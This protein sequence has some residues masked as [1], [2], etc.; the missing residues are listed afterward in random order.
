MKRVTEAC[1]SSPSTSPCTSP[2]RPPPSLL[3]AATPAHETVAKR[4]RLGTGMEPIHKRCCGR[5]RCP[6]I[7]PWHLILYTSHLT[8]HHT[9]VTRHK[10][11]RILRELDDDLLSTPGSSF[12]PSMCV[13]HLDISACRM[14]AAA[15]PCRAPRRSP[16][17]SDSPPPLFRCRQNV[18]HPHV[19][20]HLLQ[21]A[22]DR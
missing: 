14:A 8:S 15:C 18:P 5:E 16:C 11:P 20:R 19:S 6:H 3:N 4:R 21:P 10:R 1:Y 22:S 7:T 17:M 13:M 12:A 2:E 9:H